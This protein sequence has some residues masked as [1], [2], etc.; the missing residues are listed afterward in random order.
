MAN[1]CALRV[2]RAGLSV[3]AACLFAL[4]PAWVSAA[5][6]AATV[7]DDGDEPV[8][9]AEI[10]F[11]E[12]DEERQTDT[13]GEVQ[14]EFPFGGSHTLLIRSEAFEPKWVELDIA[15]GEVLEKTFVLVSEQETD[16]EDDS[17][18]DEPLV[19]TTTASPLENPVAYQPS[20]VLDAE[21]LQR[22][23][24]NSYGEMLDGTPGVA[25]RSFGSAPSRPVIRGLGGERVLVLQNGERTGDV[26]STAHDHHIA[27]DPL[28]AD[29]VEVIRGPASL[30]YGSSA[31]GGVVN[32]MDER[33]PRQW[34]DGVF[35]EAALYGATGQLSG[36]GAA[37]MGYGFDDFAVR[38]RASHR[39]AGDL[40]TPTQTIPDTSIQGTT[41]DV[42]ASRR[43]DDGLQG[44][45]LGFQDLDFGLPEEH[46]DPDESVELRSRRF[47][48]QTR[49]EQE[50]SGF[51]E[52]LEWRLLANHY[53]H[54]EI[55][56]EPGPTGD[57]EE[58]LELGYDVLAASSSLTL[59]HGEVGPVDRGAVG[60]QLRARQLELA[61]DEVLSPDAR[62]GAIA[63]YLFEEIPLSEIVRLQFGLRPEAHLFEPRANAEFDAP[64]DTRITPTVSGSAGI[65]LQP[66]EQVEIGA[67]LA[68]A[69]RAPIVEELYSDAPHLGTGQ[70]EIGDAGLDNEVGY[71][72]D[73]YTTLTGRFVQ[74]RMSVFINHVQNFIFLQPTGEDDV[75]SGYPIYEYRSADA[76]LGGAE[77][78][79]RVRPF[80]DIELRSTVDWVRG[81]RLAPS[82][83]PLPSIPPLRGRIEA[84]WN[85]DDLWA[86]G[87][88]RTA[89]TQDRTAPEEEATPGY[90][91]FD[92]EGGARV[93]AETGSHVLS[94]RM[95]N[96]FD[97]PYRDHLS[98]VR[99]IASPMP[100]RSVHATYRWVY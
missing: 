39:R 8:A 2:R 41:A 91:L 19:R 26:S 9:G 72:A 51:F 99:G 1:F 28:E 82:G 7:V 36:A 54:D 29:R 48:A 16:D 55:E 44:L 24:A 49:A 47:F 100:G 10:T 21:Q 70:Y 71:G 78:T 46:D 35:S 74:T 88:M 14:F 69:H 34:A 11:L 27:I 85:A 86:M 23:Q 32:I 38:G 68:R 84:G 96:I 76:R 90:A 81:Q 17:S 95:S 53:S 4:I 73:L 13:E 58:E 43:T 25:A 93:V 67:Q 45:S 80:R 79:T 65:N 87:R 63:A 62:E 64:D 66:L 92:V 6:L 52:H 18:G 20:E 40:Q 61:G 50:L 89:A 77:W 37:E 31:L 30:L 15:D 60:L 56:M 42:G 57:I 33:I 22:R 12:A 94:V 98:R 59:R 5:E 75:E 83:A 3:A 97:T